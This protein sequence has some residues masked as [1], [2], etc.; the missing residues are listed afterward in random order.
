MSRP[1]AVKK[2]GRFS[3]CITRTVPSV[4]LYRSLSSA[5]ALLTSAS[6]LRSGDVTLLVD[7][8]EVASLFLD[9]Y[10]GN[11]LGHIRFTPLPIPRDGGC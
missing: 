4:N 10:L 6:H 8:V 9:A 1:F 5:A 7:E 3:F 11:F 2:R